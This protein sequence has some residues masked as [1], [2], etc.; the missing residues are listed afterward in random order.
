MATVL[1]TKKKPVCNWFPDPWATFWGSASVR[2]N[3]SQGRKGWL[4]FWTK[5]RKKIS[6]GWVGG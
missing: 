4:N 5:I 6:P 3:F 1:K 2:R